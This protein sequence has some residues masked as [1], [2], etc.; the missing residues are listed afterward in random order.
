[1]VF[2]LCSI[3]FSVEVVIMYIDKTNGGLMV[4]AYMI[5]F[6]FLAYWV[7]IIIKE[8]AND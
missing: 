7:I 6:G 2:Y 8:V 4:Y 5:G 3:V 1:V